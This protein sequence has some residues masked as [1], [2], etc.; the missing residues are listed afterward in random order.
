M[1]GMCKKCKKRDT[2]KT[3]CKKAKDYVNQDQVP[4]ME[5]LVNINIENREKDI[6][7]DLCDPFDENLSSR[8]IKSRYTY[9]VIFLWKDGKSTS[10]IAYHVPISISQIQRII[11]SFK[12]NPAKFRFISE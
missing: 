1:K 3:L 9:A 11:K 8:I 2:C 12:E 6:D 10:E 4:I 5:G 7:Y